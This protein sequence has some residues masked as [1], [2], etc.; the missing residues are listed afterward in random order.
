MLLFAMPLWVAIQIQA[1]GT[2]VVAEGAH[3]GNPGMSR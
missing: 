3:L 2:I 1:P